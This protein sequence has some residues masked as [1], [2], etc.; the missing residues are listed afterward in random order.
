MYILC[1]ISWDDILHSLCLILLLF[2]DI[3]LFFNNNSSFFI[4]CIST[5]HICIEL[6]ERKNGIATN[7]SIVVL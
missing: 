2:Y 4:L 5:Q 7:V 3:K 1:N 6:N